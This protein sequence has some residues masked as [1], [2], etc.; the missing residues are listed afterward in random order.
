MKC[1]VVILITVGLA[2][3]MRLD[4]DP[5]KTEDMI[6]N[7]DIGQDDYLY[8]HSTRLGEPVLFIFP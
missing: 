6:M 2:W 4:Q 3:T 8:Y 7:A 5:E 1:L